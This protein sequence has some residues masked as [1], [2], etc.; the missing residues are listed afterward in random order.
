MPPTEDLLTDEKLRPGELLFLLKDLH[1]KVSHALVE[2][3]TK[4][5]FPG[6]AS[7]IKFQSDN[8]FFLFTEAVTKK[9]AC[10]KQASS[11]WF[12]KHY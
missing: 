6:V 5:G 11:A 10:L 8:R 9:S 1:S 3:K 7:K 12:N 4:K 2:S